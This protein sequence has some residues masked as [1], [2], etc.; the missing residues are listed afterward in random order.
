MEIL[1]ESDRR[2]LNCLNRAHAQSFGRCEAYISG[3]SFLYLRSEGNEKRAMEVQVHHRKQHG[4]FS[5]DSHFN[6][7]PSN[8]EASCTKINCLVQ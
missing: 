1:W 5:L 6:S 7:R 3:A 2:D 4:I 8:K